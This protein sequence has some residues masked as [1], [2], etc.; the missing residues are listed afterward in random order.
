M[1]G[2]DGWATRAAELVRARVRPG[3]LLLTIGAGDVTDLG[4]LVLEVLRE[5]EGESEGG[6]EGGS[7][8]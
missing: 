5:S 2:R 6:S 3:D 8:G 7:E 4:P 1:A